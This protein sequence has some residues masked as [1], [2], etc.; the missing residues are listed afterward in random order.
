MNV[1]MLVH[2][3]CKIC[4]N[5]HEIKTYYPSVPDEIH[6][7][8]KPQYALFSNIQNHVLNTIFIQKIIRNDRINHICYNCSYFFW[9]RISEV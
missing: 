7:T 4:P 9:Y 6:S 1:R 5:Y 8:Y 2:F 3:D